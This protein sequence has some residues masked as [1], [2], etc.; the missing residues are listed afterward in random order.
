MTKVTHNL[1]FKVLA[2]FLAVISAVLSL[3]SVAA[4]IAGGAK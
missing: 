4:V 1:G 2:L 3:T